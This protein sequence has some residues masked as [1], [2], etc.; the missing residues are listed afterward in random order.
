MTKMPTE[1]MR[2][3]QRTRRAEIRKLSG[4]AVVTV[5]GAVRLVRGLEERVGR[6][7]EWVK[8]VDEASEDDGK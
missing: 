8:E 6:L 4:D 1:K 7:E 2:L 3:Y 5:A